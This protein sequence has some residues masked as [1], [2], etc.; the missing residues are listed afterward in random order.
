MLSQEEDNRKQLFIAEMDNINS[1]TAEKVLIKMLIHFRVKEFSCKVLI[2]REQNLEVEL[3][4][5]FKG[6]FICLTKETLFL[7]GYGV[8]FIPL[9]MYPG[10]GN[11]NYI[12]D[13]ARDTL[14]KRMLLVV[15]CLA[16][17]TAYAMS[18]FSFM[19]E[20]PF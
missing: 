14:C 4:E 1:G 13:G 3:Q 19:A 15:L 12:K 2:L 7:L 6:L 5:V 10:C 17:L 20:E 8:C 16:D 9:S 18:Y 11:L